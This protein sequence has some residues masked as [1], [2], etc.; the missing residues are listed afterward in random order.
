MIIRGRTWKFGDNVNTDL[1]A[2]GKYLKLSNREMAKHLMEGIDPALPQKIKP[3]DIIVGG[4]NFGCGSSR[5][6]APAAIKYAGVG[7]VVARSFARI[8]FRNAINLG[9]P[10]LECPQIGEIMPGDELEIDL[11]N[12]VIK[13]L[14]RGTT[15]QATRLPAHIMEILNAG[16]LVPYLER[17]MA[18]G[19]NKGS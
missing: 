9:L 5:E 6:T 7:A 11:E 4:S 14:A 15:Y 19:K 16:G 3:G 1:I 17:E 8:F 2:P 18:A 13:N 10:V 12:G